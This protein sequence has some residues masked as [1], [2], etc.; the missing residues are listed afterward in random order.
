M[1]YRDVLARMWV[2]DP[3][4]AWSPLLGGLKNLGQAPKHHLVDPALAARLVGATAEALLG[5]GG[6]RPRGGGVFLGALFESL[7]AQTMRALAQA[8]GAKVF[9]L[10]THGGQHEIDLVVQRRDLK[11]VAFEVKLSSVVRPADVAQLAWLRHQ[12]PDLVVDTVLLN[13]GPEAYRRQDG[14]AVVP[15]AL[16]GP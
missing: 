11:I 9:H 16:L 12:V 5:G 4:P 8:V 7:A 10:R 6:P 13:T 14:V 3:L 1:V 2:L 15:L